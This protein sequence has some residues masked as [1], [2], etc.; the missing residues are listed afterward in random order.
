ATGQ[1][2]GGVFWDAGA[3]KSVA[4]RTGG[5]VKAWAQT[6]DDDNRHQLHYFLPLLPAMKTPQV[7][8]AHDPDESDPRAASQQPRYRIVG[9]SRLN[10]SFEAGHI[11]ARVTGERTHRGDPFVQRCKAAGI[12][13]WVAG[14]H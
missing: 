10:D 6:V 9:V 2:R 8:S 11:D 13:E 7:V 5:C 14:G 4:R 1:G 3:G 12:F